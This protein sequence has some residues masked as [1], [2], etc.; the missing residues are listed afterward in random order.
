MAQVLEVTVEERPVVAFVLARL[1]PMLSR[2]T[3]EHR[4]VA[5]HLAALLEA[6][7]LAPPG[8]GEI[9]LGP[10]DAY[11]IGVRGFA[12]ATDLEEY[13]LDRVAAAQG[14]EPAEPDDPE[15]SE[16]ARRYFPEM[17]ADPRSWDYRKVQPQFIDLG[18]KLDR[19]L[20]EASPR[21]RGLYNKER[22]TIVN[23]A[24]ERRDANRAQRRLHIVLPM[25]APA[26]PEP[27]FVYGTS[28]EEGAP[29]RPRPAGT[30]EAPRRSPP[31]DLSTVSA[32]TFHGAYSWGVDVGTGVS[33]DDLEP[34]R[35]R[36]T[37]AGGEN[38][39]LVNVDGKVCAVARTCPH[40]GWDL[41][42]GEVVDG[43]I[44]CGLH[45][46]QFDVCSGGV[47]REPYDPS[48]NR[49]HGFL[50]GFTGALDPKHVTEPLQSFPTRVADD[51]EVR[52]HL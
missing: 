48:F 4:E 3:A 51:G 18:F 38:L 7:D 41:S 6:L 8:P 20:S 29:S 23:A 12:L 33:G 22:Q 27:D 45:G 43:V 52:V 24:V 25:A 34:N 28:A 50:G 17:D 19:L 30:I 13:W 47:R 15:V 36:R 46:A 21:V 11:T 26:L 42:R 5:E 39:M 14:E 16:P 31:A 49:Q 35:P 32:A 44:T 2:G 37:N 9:E 1:V 40:R 10:E